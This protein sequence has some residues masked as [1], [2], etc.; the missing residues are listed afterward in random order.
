MASADL[1][2]AFECLSVR[3]DDNSEVDDIARGMSE[4]LLYMGEP[5]HEYADRRRSILARGGRRGPLRGGQRSRRSVTFDP[6]ARD[7]ERPPP[8]RPR[9]RRRGRSVSG[10]AAEVIETQRDQV[11][12]A[13]E[14]R[15]RRYLEQ[16]EAMNSQTVAIIEALQEALLH[17]ARRITLDNA[18]RETERANWN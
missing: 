15:A 10:Q 9:R 13:R 7:E 5:I 2:R 1:A 17:I 6:S 3:H 18:R 16:A 14:E 12:R 11:A 4:L 8:Y